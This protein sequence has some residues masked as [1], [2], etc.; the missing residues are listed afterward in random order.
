MKEKTAR[1]AKG[2]SG[3]AVTMEMVG[4]L[5]GVSQVTVSRA[6]NDPSKVSKATMAKIQE[7]IAATGFVPNALAGALASNRSRLISALVPSVTNITHAAMVQSFTERM[8]SH[9]YQIMLSETGFDSKEEEA[10]IGAHLSRRPDAMMLTGA[11]HTPAARRMLLA[12]NL[13]TVEIWDVTDTPIDLCV[14]FSHVDAGAVVGRFAAEQGYRT[15]ACVTAADE[16]ALRRKDA[17]CAAFHTETSVRPETVVTEGQ[18]SLRS[19]REGMSTLLDLGFKQGVVFCS[20]DQLAHGLMIETRARGLRT[21]EDIA[22][23]GFGD[24]DFAAHTLPALTTV[25]VDRVELGSRAADALLG[26]LEHGD[27]P[28]APINIGFEIIR[29]DSA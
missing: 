29:R 8:R 16:R 12:A 9:G 17:F 7:A 11:R 19:G 13:P 23:I 25:R 4:K 24:Q 26:R 3:Q 14:G 5:A 22:I 6:L 21:P 2:R 15:A 28:Q 18:A 20:S 1:A 10:L 27:A